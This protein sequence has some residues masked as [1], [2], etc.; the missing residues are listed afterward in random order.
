MAKSGS[1]AVRWPPTL[2]L[3]QTK[4]L[5]ACLDNWIVGRSHMTRCVTPDSVLTRLCERG[6]GGGGGGVTE[7]LILER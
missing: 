7:G 3:L 4:S 1:R 5:I 2:L 6:G